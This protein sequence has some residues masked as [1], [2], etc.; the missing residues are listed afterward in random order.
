MS[1][2]DSNELRPAAAGTDEAIGS[3][4]VAEILAALR[5]LRYGSLVVTTIR[6]WF[7]L[8]KREGPF[9]EKIKRRSLMTYL[10]FPA[11]SCSFPCCQY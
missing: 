7:R 1:R 4:V 10:L 5:R 11:N 3:E 6:K 2:S 9:A 8:R